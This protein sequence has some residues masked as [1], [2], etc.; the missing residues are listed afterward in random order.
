MIYEVKRNEVLQEL[1]KPNLI[2]KKL[3]C[4]SFSLSDN[5]YIS[6]QKLSVLYNCSLSG[7][8][9]LVVLNFLSQVIVNDNKFQP[10]NLQNFDFE[11]EQKGVNKIRIHLA[12]YPFEKLT[13][14]RNL[15]CTTKSMIATY[16]SVCFLK[17]KEKFLVG[18]V[19]YSLSPFY[20][21]FNIGDNA[22][23]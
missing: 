2:K 7:M 10:L 14:I 3:K 19:D 17:E 15:N 22:K 8:L 6:L 16:A 11:K 20:L 9:R 23:V 5:T 1:L 18:D 12:D 4:I 13:K 21:N